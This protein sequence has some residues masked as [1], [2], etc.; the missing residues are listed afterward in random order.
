MFTFFLERA[1]M[2]IIFPNLA[3][4]SQSSLDTVEMYDIGANTFTLLPQK[5]PYK[6]SGQCSVISNS[7]QKVY[8][9][10]G[11][12]SAKVMQRTS[13]SYDIATKTY[14]RLAGIETLH[15][16]PYFLTHLFFLT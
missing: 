11:V 10:G 8:F 3:G 16:M 6:V 14:Q 2:L 13:Y 7:R 12:N 9:I 15:I 1:A 4:F 5:F